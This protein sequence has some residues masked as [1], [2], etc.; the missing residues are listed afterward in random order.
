MT[1]DMLITRARLVTAEG[2]VDG[3]LGVAG[4]S[5][6]GIFASD[7]IPQ[8]IETVD[9]GGGYVLP[10]VVDIHVHFR[11]PGLEYKATYR[12]ESSAAAVGGVT[13]ILDMPNN[14]GRAVVNAGALAAKLEVARRSS[15]VD[16]GA[17][18]YLCS[19]DS[20]EVAELVSM[21]VA[22]FKWDMSL[23]G[24]EVAPGVHLP[25]HSDAL[26]YFEAA[27]RAGAVVGVHA[28]DRP[29]VVERTD[30]L[31]K[32]GRLDAAAHVEARPVE[33][34]TLALRQ[35]FDLCR[36]SGARLH[37]HHLSSSASVDMVREAK[38]E[39]LPVTAE[40]IP[41]FLF[42]DARDYSRLGTV[43]KI[44]PAVKYEEDRTALWAALLDGTIDCLAT[45]HAPHTA[46]EKSRDVWQASPGAIG[47]QTSLSL[48]LGAMHDG[49]IGLLRLVEV[50]CA[51][52]ARL[53]GLFP[54]KGCLLVG[55]DADLVIVDPRA[56]H[57]IRNAD[58]LTPNRLTPFDGTVVTGA[59]TVTYLRG[60]QIAHGGR[61]D[62]EPAGRH[63]APGYGSSTS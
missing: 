14:G 2:I 11:E 45:D 26:P 44:H 37:I 50:M 27:A 5:I 58:M 47:V 21:G 54:R 16:F 10:G 19:K 15:F 34:E 38:S 59:P 63:V 6:A 61:V 20:G 22:G 41:P 52:P 49:R 56:R 57:E 46:E 1:L 55:G 30:L 24:T 35:A 32:Q 17:Y 43:M 7:Q 31:R 33:A 25:E 48:M 3:T 9:V 4:G 28:E 53:Y 40:T 18:A 62:G 42:L 36:R 60:R 12:S 51:A 23:A 39:G 13:T 29:L 8:A